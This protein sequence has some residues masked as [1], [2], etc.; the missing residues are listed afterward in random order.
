M[1]LVNPQLKGRKQCEINRET[2]PR[3]FSD[4]GQQLREIVIFFSEDN[5]NIIVETTISNA[6]TV[7]RAL[8]L[9]IFRELAKLEESKK[10]TAAKIKTLKAAKGE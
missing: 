5:K 10:S 9:F 8:D 7:K 6:E 3:L 2:F 1:I 4:N